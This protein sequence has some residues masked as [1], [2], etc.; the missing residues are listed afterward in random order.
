M[1]SYKYSGAVMHYDKVIANNW[2]AETKAE[3]EVR[4][5][6][7]FKYQF[8]QEAKMMPNAGGIK[9]MGKIIAI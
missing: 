4:A 1:I 3:S 9:L 7:N 2:K 6:T 5:I 8:K